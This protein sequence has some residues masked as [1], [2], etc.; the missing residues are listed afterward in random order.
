MN[1]NE[2]IA[3]SAKVLVW[4][5]IES[6]SR[7]KNLSIENETTKILDK[8]LEDSTYSPDFVGSRW[9]GFQL[10]NRKHDPLK[11][12]NDLLKEAVSAIALGTCLRYADGYGIEAAT[13]NSICAANIGFSGYD[14]EDI[15]STLTTNDFSSTPMFTHLQQT[16][17]LLMDSKAP[18]IT[19]ATM[20]ADQIIR[21]LSVLPDS[22][23][24]TIRNA[25]LPKPGVRLDKPIEPWVES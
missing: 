21:I 16:H 22:Y 10:L 24:S 1:N 25:L 3:P 19:A 15:S 5:R 20:A 23:M 17:D 14:Q 8:G 6:Y 2:L 4:L 9:L 7:W 18:E 11:A 13:N 12:T